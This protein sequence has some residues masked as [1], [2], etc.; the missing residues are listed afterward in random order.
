MDFNALD[1]RSFG[2]FGLRVCIE[3]VRE[4]VDVTGGDVD[5][6]T[7]AAPPGYLAAPLFVVAPELL[8]QLSGYSVIHGEQVFRWAK[9]MTME[10]DHSVTGT[11][12]RV[13]ERSG[14]YF[15][16]FDMSVSDGDDEVATGSSLFLVTPAASPQASDGS[17][18]T[19]PLDRGDIGPGQKSA[20]RSDLVRYAAA[21]RDWNP[22]HWDHASATAAGLPGVVVHGLLQTAWALDAATED[23]A[24]DRPLASAKIRFRNPLLTAH[25][26]D[27]NV[28]AV[29]DRRTVV[30]SDGDTQFL[31]AQID[32][33]GE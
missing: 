31:T 33:A 1:G 18:E 3:K 10:R 9:P 23:V 15:V 5:R 17:E 16:G 30:V 8:N 32:L 26:V 24:S 28:E 29:E 19:A 7:M 11:V 14:S 6:W 21:T 12:T 2:P 27:I 25:P 22:I 4:F 20:S 13:R